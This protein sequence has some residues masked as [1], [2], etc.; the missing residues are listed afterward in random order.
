LK[1]DYCSSQNDFIVYFE[2]FPAY[3]ITYPYSAIA[4][5]ARRDFSSVINEQIYEY[6]IDTTARD[7]L[8]IKFKCLNWLKECTHQLIPL[9]TSSNDGNDL[10]HAA[11]LS[12][13]GFEDDE[14]ILRSAFHQAMSNAYSSPDRNTIHDRCHYSM[15]RIMKSV[16]FTLSGQ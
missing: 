9:H 15:A 16:G 3:T 14:F 6:L 2:S 8:E 10:F 4:S 5:V 1:K 12:M 11:S 13:W 7:S